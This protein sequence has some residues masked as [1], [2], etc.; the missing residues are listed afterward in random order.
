MVETL[1]RT[2]TP[3]AHQ[4]AERCYE[5]AL[6]EEPR[7]DQAGYFVRETECWRDPI[8]QQTVRVQYT[9][10]PEGGFLTIEEARA[11]YDLQKISRA[12]RGFVHC[13]TPRYDPK[14]PA[15]YTRVVIPAGTVREQKEPVSAAGESAMSGQQQG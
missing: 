7:E 15:P 14:K 5:L 4:L 2:K 9:L 6:G 8:T 12:L 1:Y 3:I 13:F 10:S 11:R